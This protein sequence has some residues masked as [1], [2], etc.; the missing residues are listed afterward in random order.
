[1][2][3]T[4][5]ATTA[6][7]TTTNTSSSSV[8]PPELQAK[9]GYVVKVAMTLEGVTKETFDVAKFT[10]GI[11]NAFNREADNVQV[12]SVKEVDARRQLLAAGLMVDF[13]VVSADAD[14]A[15]MFAS[16]LK[17]MFLSEESQA[18]M[19]STLKNEGLPVTAMRSFEAEPKN[20]DAPSAGTGEET[21]TAVTSKPECPTGLDKFG[22][23]ECVAAGC[24][25]QP[26][27]LFCGKECMVADA[28]CYGKTD[29][30][31]AVCPSDP[32]AP[33][34]IIYNTTT[35]ITSTTTTTA[36]A[37][38]TTT[39]TTTTT[40]AGTTT[41]TITSAEQAPA[42]MTT[43]A[44]TKPTTSGSNQVNNQVA[45]HAVVAIIALVNSFLL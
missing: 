40:T 8:T 22:C 13:Q 12:L 23:A 24:F 2:T 3:T 36:A 25:W 39:T 32:D 42:A 11:A 41:T 21:T 34:M 45:H 10:A 18:F 16:V 30:W 15:T 4:T 31:H 5:Q 1:M 9:T 20:L 7:A 43:A 28:S 17:T 14:D 44:I 38:A 35:T 27:T 29:D 26:V 37:A 6:A 19:V 33:E